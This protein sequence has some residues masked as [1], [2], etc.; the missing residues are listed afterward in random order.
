MWNFFEPENSQWY[1]WRLDGS[2]VYL[3]RNGEEW[4]IAFVPEDFNKLHV[5]CGGPDKADPPEGTPI[6]FGVSRAKKVALKPR[7]N[8]L[9]Y[10]IVSRNVVRILPGAEA[11]F[12][13]ALPPMVRLELENGDSLGEAMP[14]RLSNTWFGDTTAGTLCLSLPTALDPRCHGETDT[15]I[16]EEGYENFNSLVHCE[17]VVRNESKVP[18]DLK[19]L[20]IYT[21]L[22]GIYE[23]DGRLTTDVVHINSLPDGGLKMT[24]QGEGKKGWH[25]LTSRSESGLS[26]LLVRR[27]VNFLRSMTGL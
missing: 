7:L 21:D 22:L 6:S 17:I 12:D 26:E 13:V 3:R 16:C 5:D 9:P 23:K 25:R 18:V 24:V 19:R 27:G 1:R 20:A 14:Y 4:R 15:G 10:L 8:A 2:L 11:S